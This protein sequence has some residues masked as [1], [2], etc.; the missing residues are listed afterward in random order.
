M[1]P[2]AT[3]DTLLSMIKT[4]FFLVVAG[5]SLGA[6]LLFMVQPMAGKFL[7]PILG[8]G[9]SIWNTAM[10]FFQLLLLAGYALAHLTS[11]L[12]RRVQLV[13]PSAL[14]LLGLVVSLPMNV[15]L[16]ILGKPDVTRPIFW[17]F[18]ALTLMVGLPFLAL[19]M[20]SPLLQGWFA[21]AFPGRNAYTLYRA[22]NIGSFLGLLAYPFVVEPLLTLTQQ[23]MAWTIGF[24]VLLV[25]LASLAS[26]LWNW[27]PQPAVTVATV[28]EDETPPTWADYGRWIFLAF[29]PSALLLGVT[30]YITTDVAS[31][32]LFWII[33]LALYLLTFVFGFSDS[34]LPWIPIIRAVQFAGLL[35]MLWLSSAHPDFSQGKLVGLHLSVFFINAFACHQLLYRSRPASKHLTKFYLT[36]STGGAL[37]GVC[38]ALIAPFVFPLPFEYAIAIGLCA[39]TLLFRIHPA[40]NSFS[41]PIPY[42]RLVAFALCAGALLYLPGYASVTRL[43]IGMAMVGILGMMYLYQR[44]LT[45]LLIAAFIAFPLYPWVVL[46]ESDAIRRTYFGVLR[47][48]DEDGVRVLTNGTTLHG[49]QLI[50][51][52]GWKIALSYYSRYSPLADVMHIMDER[53]PGPQRIAGLGLGVGSIACY[54]REGRHFT[55]FDIDP[56]VVK[57]AQDERYFHYLSNCGSPYD[58]KLGDARLTLADEPDASYDV[59]LVDTFSSDSIPVHMLTSEALDIYM[60]KLKPFGILLFHTSNRHFNL[61]PEIA[62]IAYAKNLAVLKRS[63]KAGRIVNKV[64]A[65]ETQ[66][67][68]VARTH[69]ILDPLK[70]EAEGWVGVPEFEGRPWSDNYVNILRA[71]GNQGDLPE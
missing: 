43:L 19:S 67:V 38:I 68:A 8:G 30:A 39:L 9:P 28:E 31:M 17:Q 71:L 13:L 42:K 4:R 32:P 63:S 61:K 66:Y 69:T 54:P 53:A 49:T 55:F 3:Q 48:Y 15:P 47:I 7:L 65:A 57:I 50:D 16:D 46:K 34:L 35:A 21:A 26:L 45:A 52:V 22:S 56:E 1:S 64:Y 36:V 10:V 29:V 18:S 24:T 62:R 25:T 6:F 58:I 60:A 44:T 2:L 14:L 40:E 51:R 59:I 41:L 20:L 5:I 27:A 37:G 12:P 11:T 23:S 33:P 70:E